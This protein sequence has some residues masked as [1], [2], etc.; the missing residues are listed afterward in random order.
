MS[1]PPGP[2]QVT[3]FRLAPR[4]RQQTSPSPFSFLST[5][6]QLP[7]HFRGHCASQ[8]GE[9]G[10]TGRFFPWERGDIVPRKLSETTGNISEILA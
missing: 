8:A 3:S 9:M 6:V 5:P 2:T 10:A 1:H 4:F 7:P